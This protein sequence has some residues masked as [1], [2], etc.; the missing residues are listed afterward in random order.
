MKSPLAIYNDTAKKF[1]I[2]SD[3]QL[4]VRQKT[5]YVT[6]QVQAMQ[7]VA[8]RLICDIVAT[9]M[10]LDDAKDDSTKAAIQNK[11]AS[12]ENDLRQTSMGM[13]HYIKLQ[14]ELSAEIGKSGEEV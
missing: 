14:E 2:T 5:A 6:E 9:T 11:L 12:Y 7:A 8:N 3:K 10:A 4:H 1:K 13:D